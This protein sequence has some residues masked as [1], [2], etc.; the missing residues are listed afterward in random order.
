MKQLDQACKPPNKPEHQLGLTQDLPPG[1]M[2]GSLLS[3]EAK[4]NEAARHL[5]V[6]RVVAARGALPVRGAPNVRVFLTSPK[7]CNGACDSAWC[8]HVELLL[9]VH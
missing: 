1:E 4:Y 5:A 2:R 9:G 3:S 7:L 6:A 8:P